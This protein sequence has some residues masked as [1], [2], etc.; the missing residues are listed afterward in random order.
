VTRLDCLT[1]AHCGCRGRGWLPPRDCYGPNVT[2]PLT[3]LAKPRNHHK[4]LSGI[5]GAALLSYTKLFPPPCA[6]VAGGLSQL[7]PFLPSLIFSSPSPT[8]GHHHLA[9]PSGHTTRSTDQTLKDPSLFCLP[10]CSFLIS[11]CR[12]PPR[13]WR[14]NP[15]LP[16]PQAGRR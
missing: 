2:P 13:C 1:V 6:T 16:L 15:L 10:L 4:K 8:A 7:P 3:G 5:R 12:W 11:F 9:A 14:K